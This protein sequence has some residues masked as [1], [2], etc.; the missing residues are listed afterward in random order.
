MIRDRI[1][2]SES[3]EIFHGIG[4]KKWKRCEISATIDNTDKPLECLAELKK[5]VQTF[6]QSPQ[7]VSVEEALEGVIPVQQVETRVDILIKDIMACDEIDKK[8]WL[9]T[10]VGL[11]AYAN[12]TNPAIKAAFD[13]RMIQLKQK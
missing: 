8:N 5:D 9:G 6:L 10:Q 7:E 13:L 1:V 12:E 11:L 3:V 2:Y 4:L